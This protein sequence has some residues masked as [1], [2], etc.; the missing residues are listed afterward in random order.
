[1]GVHAAYLEMDPIRWFTPVAYLKSSVLLEEDQHVVQLERKEPYSAK[2]GIETTRFASSTS[3][4]SPS[5]FEGL[6][7]YVFLGDRL[8]ETLR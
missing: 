8:H 6:H 1:M 4:I 2:A 7:T 3:A 5:Q